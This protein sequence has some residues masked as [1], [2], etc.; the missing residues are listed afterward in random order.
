MNVLGINV[1][2]ILAGSVIIETV[3]AWPGVGLYLIDG[4]VGRDFPV[5]Q[6]AGLLIASSV[7]LVNLLT[8][9]MLVLRR[10][11]HSL[12]M[13]GISASDDG[14][15]CP[16]CSGVA[17]WAICKAGQN[18]RQRERSRWLEADEEFRRLS[19]H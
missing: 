16:D 10:S 19:G 2:F 17:R 6:G 15:D 12:R 1:A 14:A 7:V 18:K 9:V 3:F 4:V 11:A 5:V 8:D 13:I